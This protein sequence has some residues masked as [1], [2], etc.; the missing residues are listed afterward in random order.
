[1]GT[2]VLSKGKSIWDV[3]LTRHFSVQPRLRMRGNLS[4]LTYSSGV[5]IE[6]DSTAERFTRI[7][8]ETSITGAIFLDVA[9]AF[10]AVWNDGILYNLTYLNIPPY[11]FHTI[12]SYVLFPTFEESFQTA[13]HLVEA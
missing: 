10:D 8:G 13:R 12:S 6:E 2:G 4:L 3:N 9:K 11:T 1:M 5:C 7:Y